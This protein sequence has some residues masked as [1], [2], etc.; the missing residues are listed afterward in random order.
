MTITVVQMAF[1][2]G[3]NREQVEQASR[4]SAPIFR[5]LPGLIRKHYLLSMETQTWGGVYVWASREQAEAFYTD[6]FCQHIRDC[7]GVE[8]SIT[9]FDSPLVVENQAENKS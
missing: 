4:E 1:P 2:D 6:L 5:N 7:Y 8:P 3:W 9:L